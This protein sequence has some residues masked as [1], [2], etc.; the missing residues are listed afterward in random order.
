MG[1]GSA[2][3]AD[4]ADAAPELKSSIKKAVLKAEGLLK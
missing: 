1:A 3:G 2:D 4:R